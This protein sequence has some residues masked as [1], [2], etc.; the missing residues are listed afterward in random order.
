M[1]VVLALALVQVRAQD[2]D[3]GEAPVD[4]ERISVIASK[5]PRPVRDVAGTVTV[6]DRA[7]IEDNAV[8]D[9]EDLV[10]YEPAISVTREAGRFGLD[11]FSIRGVGGNRVAVELDGVP[12]P[13]GFDV[14]DFSNAG[15]DFVD[16]EIIGRVEILR[17]P[18]SSIYGSDALGGVVTYTTREPVTYLQGRNRKVGGALRVGYHGDDDAWSA[19]AGAAFSAGAV[20]GLFIGGRREGHELEAGGATANPADVT[21]TSGLAKLVHYTGTG[22]ATRL[23]L[24]A[25][26]LDRQTEVRSLIGA[27]GRFS[28]TTALNGDDGHRR[29]R[30]SLEHELGAAGRFAE[31]GVVRVFRQTAE[32]T[33]RTVEERSGTPMSPDPTRREREF[34][35][36]QTIAGGEIT[37]ERPARFWGL[38]HRFVYG[39]ELVH[40][41]TEEL[42]DATLTNLGTGTTTN[43]ILGEVFPLRDF[44]VTDTLEAGAYV[45]DEIALGTDWM[46]IPALRLEYYDLSPDPD[47]IYREDFPGQD[48]T[49]VTE[50]SIAP[51]LAVL[52][53]VG[54]HGSVFLQYARGFRAPPFEDVNIGLEIPMF[55]IRAIPNPDLEAETSD[56]LELG[57]RHDGRHFDFELGLFYT[58]FENLIVSRVPVGFDPAS[59][60]LLFQSVNREEARIYGGEVGSRWNLAGVSERLDGWTVRTALAVVRGDDTDRDQP[61]NSIDPERAVL[62]LGYR[63]PD[64]AWRVEMVGTFS[65]AKTRIDTSGDGELFASPGYGVVDL[66]GH[67][68]INESL[69]LNWGVFNLFDKR[70]WQWSDVQGLPADDPVIP[71]SARPGRHVSASL[72][73]T[74]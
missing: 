56:G 6:I 65:D 24:D 68:R 45:Q 42:R 70:Y 9:I 14:G 71:L 51:K 46:L 50:T 59:G 58:D 1:A 38:D 48:I 25:G 12:V 40:T 15:R 55:G 64:N 47:A 18:A 26:D 16:T 35:Y 57:Y 73:M 39:A 67:V 30:I 27:P 63:A 49:G 61:L 13:D 17:G 53:H 66:L 4:L 37:L 21:A 62:G 7:Y 41:E 19:S 3:N 69:R 54:D 34:D 72:R 44:P 33:Q 52:R 28:T 20:D 31:S 22:R 5:V 32:T 23:I 10:R 2:G 11:G 29:E 43:V 60:F 8:E 36:S 74:Y